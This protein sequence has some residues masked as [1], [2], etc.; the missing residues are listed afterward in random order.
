MRTVYDDG[1]EIFF[2][3]M[4]INIET[5]GALGP[6]RRQVID[7]ISK[8]KEESG[9]VEGRGEA[10]GMLGSARVKLIQCR[11]NRM[12][13]SFSGV[14]PPQSVGGS[15]SER[16]EPL[17]MRKVSEAKT[18]NL[19]YAEYLKTRHDLF[20]EALNETLAMHDSFGMFPN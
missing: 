2:F 18:T 1:Q 14:D 4:L 15:Q 8:R 7:I 20:K 3:Y 6:R 19:G 16:G 10:E 5:L 9:F 11:M 17:N 13:G 12:K